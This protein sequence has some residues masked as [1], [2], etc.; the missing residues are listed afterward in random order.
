MQRSLG[1][2]A[3]RT[4]P[5]LVALD[6]YVHAKARRQHE[7]MGRV[8]FAH[9]L[10]MRPSMTEARNRLMCFGPHDEPAGLKRHTAGT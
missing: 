4:P 6:F 10:K 2:S 7:R 1:D 9:K 5:R 3:R 8:M